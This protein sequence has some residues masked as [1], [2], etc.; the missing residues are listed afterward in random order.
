L[1]P[2]FYEASTGNIFLD[3]KSIS[4]Y[5]IDNL[6]SHIALVSQDITLFNDTIANN[7]AYG[8]LRGADREAVREAA[9]IAH[10]S[11]FVERLPQGF[12]T[13]VGDKG[14]L[15]SGGQRQRI[16]IARALLKNAPVLILDEATASLDSESEKII[17]QALAQLM[18][19]RTTLVIAHRL[20]T[21]ENANRI[22]VMDEGRIVESGTHQSLLAANG[23]Y[24]GLHKL[25]FTEHKAD[26][27]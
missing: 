1:L 16:A 6:R 25:Q 19:N 12:E 7:I 26:K 11:D 2:R 27:I 21:V 4:D 8:A 22:V 20:A 14:V 15:L 18:K 17:Q 3:G 13:Q 23:V 10:V 24:S 5:Q 9:R